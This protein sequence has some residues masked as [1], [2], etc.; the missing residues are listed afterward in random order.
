[1]ANESLEAGLKLCHEW[2]I[3]V[4]KCPQKKKQM[5]SEKS[6]GFRAHS[7]KEVMRIMKETTVC[8]HNEMEERFLCLH[9][10]DS[11]F[12]SHLDVKGILLTTTTN[13][14]SS[15]HDLNILKKSSL[16]HG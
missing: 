7:K 1:M 11:K 8:M 4:E 16:N 15:N 6:Q 2:D 12:G 10:L 9:D 13:E 14:N 5:P 3:Q